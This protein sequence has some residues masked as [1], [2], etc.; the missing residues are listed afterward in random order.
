[1]QI[2]GTGKIGST[3]PGFHLSRADCVHENGEASS[4]TSYYPLPS[5][6]SN[7]NLAIST[8]IEI[9]VGWFVSD[10]AMS[11][12]QCFSVFNM[13]VSNCSFEIHS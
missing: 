10:C 2:Q 3:N 1:M 6:H 8:C 11:D 7:S 13:T 5:Y 12:K 9:V 4:K